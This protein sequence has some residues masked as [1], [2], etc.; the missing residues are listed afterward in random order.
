[1]PSLEELM[2]MLKLSVTSLLITYANFIWR[3]ILVN[4]EEIVAKQDIARRYH[5]SRRHA[6]WP[7]HGGGGHGVLCNWFHSTCRLFV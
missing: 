7:C 4:I 5:D 6:I 3:H 2:V 1:M